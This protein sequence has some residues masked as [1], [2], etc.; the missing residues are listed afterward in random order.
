MV[1]FEYQATLAARFS[2]DGVD[3]QVRE[4]RPMLPSDFSHKFKAAARRY[5]IALSF[6]PYPR[7]VYVDGCVPAG[8]W[9]DLALAQ[10]ELVHLLDD[11]EYMLADKGYPDPRYFI[12]PRE[13]NDPQTLEFN[14]RQKAIMARHEH[15]NNRFSKFACLANVFRHD[16]DN[17]HSVCV[18]AVANIINCNL[19]EIPNS[20]DNGLGFRSV[21]ENECF[22]LCA[23]ITN[24]ETT[25]KDIPIFDFNGFAHYLALRRPT[26]Q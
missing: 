5:N 8:A 14:R 3:F 18:F 16:R 20:F 4:Q 6:G 15:I 26:R 12:T 23:Y 9:N 25:R 17:F 24:C 10:H 21:F 22:V 11:D 2:L 1:D 13:G 7:I 19:I